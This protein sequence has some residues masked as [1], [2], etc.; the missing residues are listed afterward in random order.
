MACLVIAEA[1]VNH[2]G[3][4]ELAH[5]MIEVAARAGADAVK[6]QTFQA[7]KLVTAA[8]QKAAYQ[9]RQTG[10]GS[11]MEMLRALELSEKAYG[12]L[13]DHCGELG[14]EFMSTPFD[15]ESARF[16]VSLGMKRLKIPS[17]EL[18]NHPLVAALAELGPP[19]IMSTG[20][21]TLDE[22]R[23]SV[24]VVRSAR[25]KAGSAEVADDWLTL[26]HCTSNYPARL[27]EV[28]LRAMT[29]LAREL[30]L[31]VG[32]S[33][34]T[35]GT[36]VP[37]L[38]CALGAT[39]IEKHFTL[40]RSMPGPDHKASL[41]PDELSVMVRDVRATEVALGS[42]EKA[43][44]AAELEVRA[45]ARRSVTLARAVREGQALAE[46][47]LVILRPGNGI[48]PRDLPAVIGKT[49]RASLEAGHTLQWDDLS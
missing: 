29:T 47:D 20:M 19:L 17:G 24:A 46:E 4:E 39:V 12:R 45:V 33:D 5:Q 48:Q 26:L 1:G 10:S 49:V 14:I 36:L 35:E 44:S 40:D 23:E 42:A 32:Y 22:V 25:E 8:A 2:N 34:H 21:A 18:T 9:A 7:E 3:S 30:E 13:A 15:I 28:N 41:M 6:F 43:P 31:P 11:Q 16:L 37:S 27:E 38:A